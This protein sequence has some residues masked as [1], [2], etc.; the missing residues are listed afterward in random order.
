MKASLSGTLATMGPAAPYAFA[1]KTAYPDRPVI[2]MAGDGAMQMSG[3]ND[4]VTFA[5]H[6]RQ[7]SDPRLIML[8][9]NNSDLNQVTWEMRVMTGNPKFEASQNV[10][11]FPYATYA[12]MLGL[13]GIVVD[14]TQAIGPAWDEAFAADRPVV[15]D[16]HTDPNVPPLPPHITL[17]Q[18][19]NFT[20]ALIKGDVDAL[21]IVRATL[22][23]EWE[24]LAP[25]GHD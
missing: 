3:I 18:A 24:E 25:R 17:K 14:R 23:E 8:V 19:K 6:W 16:A 15:I 9:L 4:L 1:A 11:E 5:R 2:A 22:N 7:W 10:P 13:R 12:R 20:S 21:G